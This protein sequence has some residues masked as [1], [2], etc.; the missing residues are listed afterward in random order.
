[1]TSIQLAC[2][3][4]SGFDCLWDIGWT[5]LDNGIQ[6]E[7]GV[8]LLEALLP[9]RG[10]WPATAVRCTATATATA[11]ID[12]KVDAKEMSTCATM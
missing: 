1:M 10:F 4:D 8:Q 5:D 2:S 12:R 3:R 7:V 11:Y 6:E 9:R